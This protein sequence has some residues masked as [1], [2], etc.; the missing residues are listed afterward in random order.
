MSVR[1]PSAVAVLLLAAAAVAQTPPKSDDKT[2]ADAKKADD[3]KKGDEKKPAKKTAV[4]KVTVPQDDAELTI[5]G[6]PT[7]TTGTVREFDVPDVEAGKP[8]EYEFVVKWAPN[9]Y[10]TITRTKV[11]QF[12]GGADAITADLTTGDEK[13]DKVVI[14]YVPT[15][16]DIVKKML[17]LGKVG[18]DDVVYDL[19][20]GDGRIVVA[21]VRDAKAKR[22]VGIDLDPERVKESTENAKKANVAD[23]VEI[24]KGDILEQKDLA[25]ATVVTIYLSDEFG[26]VLGPVLKR[27]LKPGTRIVSHRFTLGDWKPDESKTVTGED[28]DE[29]TL[30]LWTV[31]GKK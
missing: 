6:Q 5:L 14:R 29:Y 10:T 26:K 12:K 2:P 22:G 4:L 11:V 30:H 19:G 17:D 21:A 15:P 7:K 31:P 28:G 25:D 3:V 8:F 18:K 13:T 24:R 1:L 20:C 16:D 23:R 27:T 9:N